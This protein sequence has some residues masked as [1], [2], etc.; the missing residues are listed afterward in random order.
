[1]VWRSTT[2]PLLLI[3]CR[4]VENVQIRPFCH[5]KEAKMRWQYTLE[6][7][8]VVRGSIW[9]MIVVILG[10]SWFDLENGGKIGKFSLA[11]FVGANSGVF[12]GFRAER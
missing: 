10:F 6:S 1:M 5:R 9:C 3:D 2:R 8:K 4:M 11:I 12:F 7:G